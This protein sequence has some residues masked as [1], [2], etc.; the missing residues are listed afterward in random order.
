LGAWYQDNV[1]QNTPATI[2]K[3][4]DSLGN[5]SSPLFSA[6]WLAYINK[7][8]DAAQPRPDQSVSQEAVVVED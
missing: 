3:T 1:W 8:Y 5:E 2:D 7:A 4:V 6:G